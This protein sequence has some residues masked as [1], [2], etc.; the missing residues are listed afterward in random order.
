MKGQKN[1]ARAE[2]VF[3]LLLSEILNKNNKSVKTFI[4]FSAHYSAAASRIVQKLDFTQISA[5]M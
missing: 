1:Q 5:L 3:K 2:H 4:S